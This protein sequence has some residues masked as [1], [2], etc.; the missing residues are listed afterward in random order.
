MSYCFSLNNTLTSQ[1]YVRYLRHILLPEIGSKGQKK[2]KNSKILCVGAGG[3]GSIILMYLAAAGVEY[4]GIVDCDEVEL[5]NLQ[6]QVLHSETFVKEPKTHSALYALNEIN[7]TCEIKKYQRYLNHENVLEILYPYDLIIDG[8][9]NLETKY[10][11]NDACLFL[12]KPFVYGAIFKFQG[13]VSVFNYRGGPNYRSI[14][15]N[16]P[17]KQQIPT[18]TETGVLG[19]LPGIIG[20]M[21][22]TEALKI[23]LGVGEILS[24]KLLVYDALKVSLN[25]VRIRN[26]INTNKQYF[27]LYQDTPCEESD[28]NQVS[29]NSEKKITSSQLEEFLTFPSKSL[30]IDVRTPQEYLIT[31]IPNAILLPLTQLDTVENINWIACQQKEKKV[32]LYCKTGARSKRALQILLQHD[33]MCYQLEGGIIEWIKRRER[34]SNPC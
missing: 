27:H 24:G 7:S 28:T 8:T 1:D 6:R 32:I 18:C 10:L 12:N 9:D 3:L 11:I 5:S 20:T 21:Q 13:Q 2:I 23:I 4:I 29:N 17:H 33:I 14:Y 31:Q 16:I 22:C 26:Q 30:I 19:V 15:P 34:D 25:T